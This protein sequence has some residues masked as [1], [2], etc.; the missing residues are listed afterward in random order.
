[1]GPALYTLTGLLMVIISKPALIYHRGSSDCVVD[2][3]RSGFRLRH[4]SSAKPGQ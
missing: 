2:K 1:M 3:A 4:F